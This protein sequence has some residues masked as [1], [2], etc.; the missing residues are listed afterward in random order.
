MQIVCTQYI[1]SHSVFILICCPFSTIFPLLSSYCCCHIFITQLRR[2]GIYF[3]IFLQIFKGL[4][5]FSFCMIM[6]QFSCKVFFFPINPID[7]FP[8][9]SY[10]V[11]EISIYVF[12]YLERYV[13]TLSKFVNNIWIFFGLPFQDHLYLARIPFSHQLSKEMVNLLV[14][15]SLF[16][17]QQSIH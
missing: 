11:K 9:Y 1:V 4:T 3:E 5:T 17:T 16:N 14:S 7:F 12:F 10:S 8:V 15:R 6:I 13:Q 2:P